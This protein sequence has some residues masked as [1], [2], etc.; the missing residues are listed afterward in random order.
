MV[1]EQQAV[2]IGIIIMESGSVLHSNLR[3]FLS[4]LSG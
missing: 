1:H 3:F 2:G 4:W